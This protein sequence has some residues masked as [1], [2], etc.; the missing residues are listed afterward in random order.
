MGARLPLPLPIVQLAV[1][2][3]ALPPDS[4]AVFVFHCILCVVVGHTSRSHEKALCQGPQPEE[5]A[6]GVLSCSGQKRA[7]DRLKTFPRK[8]RPPLRDKKAC[9]KGRK[10]SP[11]LLKTC[12]KPTRGI[13]IVRAAGSLCTL[14]AL[15]QP[16]RCPWMHCQGLATASGGP[17]TPVVSRLKLLEA[18]STA[19]AR[20][21]EGPWPVQNLK[22]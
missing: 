3:Q 11:N 5:S 16:L 1:L 8:R 21:V 22:G 14:D 7:L 17:D 12:S 13:G 15:E 18:H 6:E 4:G 20:A 19:S 9:R 10:A 2:P